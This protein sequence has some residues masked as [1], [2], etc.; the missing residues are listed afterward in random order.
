MR[1]LRYGLAAL[2][3]L[4]LAVTLMSLLNTDAWFVRLLDFVRE[5]MLY[6]ALALAFLAVLALRKWRWPVV[7]GFVAVAAIELIRI[8][9]YVPM[10]SEQLALGDVPVKSQCFTALALNVKMEN[11]QYDRVA[12]LI[13]QR[14]PDALLLMEP[15]AKWLGALEEVLARYP[16]RLNKPLDNKYGMAFASRVPVTSARMVSN[17]S[18]NTPTLYATLSL[19]NG[20]EVELVGLHPRPPLPGQDTETRDANIARAGAV[21]PDRLAEVL[22]MGDFND[23]PWSRTTR[24]FVRKG[25]YSDPRIGRGTYPTFPATRT[26]IGWP[27]DQLMV[28]NGVSVD[29]FEVL[30]AVGS[31]HRPLAARLCVAAPDRAR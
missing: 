7:G 10:A 25:G 4:A 27:L 8:W 11:T 12:K 3:G 20:A 26:W 21:T 9:P 14:D 5:P 29:T 24:K 22:V 30:D 23:V 16:H 6:I 13:A 17:T 19:A 18:A 1:Y 15:N 31:D 28:K 2:S